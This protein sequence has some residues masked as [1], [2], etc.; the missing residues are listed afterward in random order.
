MIDDKLLVVLQMRREFKPE[1]MLL[2]AKFEIFTSLIIR[3][4]VINMLQC[5]TNNLARPDVSEEHG[6]FPLR[7][8]NY[9]KIHFVL[10][11]TW[12]TKLLYVSAPE[13]L[14]QSRTSR[15]M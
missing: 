12:H 13:L 11:L 15:N 7:T 3:I 14:Q 1:S 4:P 5:V 6:A 10:Q 8:G 9:R 2:V